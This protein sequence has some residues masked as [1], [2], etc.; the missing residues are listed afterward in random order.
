MVALNE[1]CRSQFE[2]AWATVIMASDVEEERVR[3]IEYSRDPSRFHPSDNGKASF[4]G[5]HGIHTLEKG[6]DEV[7]RCSCRSYRRLHP[8]ADCRHIIATQRI[9]QQ[10]V[11]FSNPVTATGLAVTLMRCQQ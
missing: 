5:D 8:V 1:Q 7:W 3:G 2:P 4:R 11:L 6:K 10:L 9:L